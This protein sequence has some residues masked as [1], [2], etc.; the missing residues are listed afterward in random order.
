MKNID[1]KEA[2]TDGLKIVE[3]KVGTVPLSTHITRRGAL[4]EE[5]FIYTA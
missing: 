3:K 5:A 2:Y 1:I 4:V